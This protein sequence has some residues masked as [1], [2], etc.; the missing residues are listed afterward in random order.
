MRKERPSNWQATLDTSKTD[1]SCFTAMLNTA[2]EPE[3]ELAR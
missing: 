1:I 2:K 3:R